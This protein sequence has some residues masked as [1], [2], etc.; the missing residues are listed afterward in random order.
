M[1]KTRKPFTLAEG[2]IQAAIL[3]KSVR[4]NDSAKAAKRF[5]RLPEF[6]HL[7]I[8][9]ILQQRIQHKHALSVIALENG[10]QSWVDFKI[11]VN[12][13]VG[14]YLNL[15]FINYEEAK[16]HLESS[17]GFLLP[18]KRQFFICNANYIKQIGFEPDDS[19]WKKI[20]YDWAMP[21]AQDAYR[22]LYKKWIEVIGGDHE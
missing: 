11:Q 5:Q 8:S 20:N 17:G 3:L 21:A 7:T 13:I 2:K 1:N 14:G 6:C 16:S 22:K 19:E 9:N 10:F 12:F 4:T 18:Y 15:W